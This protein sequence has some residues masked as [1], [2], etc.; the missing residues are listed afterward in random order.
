[1]KPPPST[2]TDAGGGQPAAQA[3]GIG[4]VAQHRHVVQSAGSCGSRRARVP[5][6]STSLA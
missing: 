2:V 4:R 3:L 1:M 6:A 5:V